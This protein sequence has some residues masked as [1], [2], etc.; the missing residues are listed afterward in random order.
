MKK[1]ITSVILVGMGLLVHAQQ[2]AQFSQNFFTK[3][4][5]NPAYAGTS[6]AYCASLDYRDQ[7]VGFPGD[8][9]T[10]AFNG[11]AWLPMIG[12]GA[13]LTAY[14]DALGFENTLEIKLSYSYHII[15]GPGILGI[16][17]SIGFFQKSLN[18][19]W[20]TPDGLGA[21]T[22]TQI[23]DPLVPVGGNSVTTY[24][25]GLGIYYATPQGLYVG[26]SSSH[27]PE[28][29]LKGSYQQYQ[30][31]VARHYY[32]M[33]GYVYNASA[34]WDVIPDVYV[35]SDASST[36][37]QLNVRA[38][39]NKTID[40]GVGYRMND[41]FV[42]LIGY[43][44]KNFEFGYSYDFTT[45]DIHSYSSGAHELAIKYCFIPKPPSKTEYHQNPRFL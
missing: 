26:I 22:K 14:S 30:Y 28:Q 43:Q 16:G 27:L 17:P 33:A 6:N 12:G 40:F 35:E 20:N 21:A 18:G 41:A 36:Q 3:L 32:V 4:N 9:K 45:S 39:Y 19:A 11:D 8:P 31:D 38:R 24:D 1:I 7:W 37:F 25:V 13:G 42:G 23:T 29:T 34:T 15:L 5:T 10:I 2:D 44:Y